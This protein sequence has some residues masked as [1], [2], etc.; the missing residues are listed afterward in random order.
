MKVLMSEIPPTR[1]SLLISL[2][3]QSEDAWSEFLSVY[4]KALFRFCRS[5]GLQDAD[6]QDVIQ[7]VMAAV[8]NKIPLWDHDSK[9]GSF[10]G[11]LFQVARN[12]AVDVIDRKAKKAQASG[13]TK[14][15]RMLAEIP[16]KNLEEST[17]E[18]EYR[19]TLFDW[20]LRQVKTEVKEVTWQSFC[21]TA[22]EGEKAESVADQLGIPVGSVYTAKC[23]VVARIRSKIAEMDDGIESELEPN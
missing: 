4:E 11:W 17:F 18:G 23:R 15:A 13:D 20:A 7:D 21:L 12:V 16:D 22:I 14:V 8:L 5:K 9:K 3:M 10:R 1:A 19:R 2:R 6:S